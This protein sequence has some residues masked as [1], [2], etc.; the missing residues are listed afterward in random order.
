MV[1][2]FGCFQIDP[3]RRQLSAA[4]A[5]LH[6]TPKAFNLL[7][8]LVE[9]APRVVTKREIHERLWNGGVVADATLVGLVKE[10]RR[11]M[12]DLSPQP[13]LRT[14]H[15]IG[16]ALDLPVVKPAAANPRASAAASGH[17]LIT[18]QRRI[19]LV[20]GENVIGR[21]AAVSVWIEHATLSRRHA[22][23]TLQAGKAVLEDLG[24]KN[25]TLL[26][27]VVVLQ[28]TPLR[29]GDVFTCGT[30]QFRYLE[31]AAVPATQTLVHPMSG[32]PR[33]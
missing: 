3:E 16:Y 17:W 28:P 4:G 29:S 9:A 32:G 6:L 12:D 14:V 11:V 18:D 7:W 19:S 8:L 33:R 27:E 23:I 15:R 5:P 30:L 13:P 25:G 24:S 1:A 21:D 10:I 20:E 26:R 22:R 2:R 31:A